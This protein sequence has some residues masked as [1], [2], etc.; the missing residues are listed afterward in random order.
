MNINAIDNLPRRLAERLRCPLPGRPAQAWF[1]P[2]LSYGRQFGPPSHDARPAAVIILLYPHQ[3]EW[4]IPLTL[5][6][7]DMTD[8]AGQVSLPGGSMEAEETSREAALRELHEELGVPPDGI[9]V[10]NPLS[11]IYVFVSNHWVTPWVAATSKR[12]SIRP[13]RAEV[14]EVLEVPLSTLL[15][16]ANLARHQIHRHGL[17]FSAPHISWRTHRIWGATGMMLGEFIAVVD[18]LDDT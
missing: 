1:S 6:P 4:H 11:P 8:H 7:A 10:L 16:S 18:G 12:P 5:R 9:E 15:D 17:T 13:N 14:A 3:N 2:E